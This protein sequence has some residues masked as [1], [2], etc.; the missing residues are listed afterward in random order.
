MNCV[1]SNHPPEKYQRIQ[2]PKGPNPSQIRMSIGIP[3][4]LNV[5][6][7]KKSI[8]IESISA[9]WIVVTEKIIRVDWDDFL[10]TEGL[11]GFKKL[12]YSTEKL[13]GTPKLMVCTY[14]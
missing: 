2:Y 7:Q 5:G 3:S 11:K 14:V 12:H 6:I 8:Y 9:T 10:S 4:S 13:H 1:V